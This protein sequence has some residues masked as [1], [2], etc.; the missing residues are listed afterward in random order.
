MMSVWANGVL[1]KPFAIN[2][3]GVLADGMVP[4]AA[5]DPDLE[6]WTKL[7]GPKPEPDQQT[8]KAGTTKND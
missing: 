7:A 8:P 6:Y 3:G 5:D 1:Y 2:H 4:V